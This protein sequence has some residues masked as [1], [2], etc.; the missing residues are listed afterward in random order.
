MIVFAPE[1]E[2]EHTITVF[3]DID[4]GYCRKL[5]RE[6]ADYNEL[7]YRRAVP[8]FSAQR[9]EHGELVKGRK[10][11][12]CRMIAMRC[13]DARPRLDCHRGSQTLAARL[14]WQPSLSTWAELLAFAVHRP[15]S[16]TDGALIPGLCAGR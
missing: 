13:T 12:V 7:R 6:I 11:L 16:P 14:P 15:S 9:A 4:C 5:H 1:Q 2:A 8:V 10:R 3:T